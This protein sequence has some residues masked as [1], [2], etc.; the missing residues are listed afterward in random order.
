MTFRFQ[1]ILA[2]VHCG[3]FERLPRQGGVG[4]GAPDIHRLVFSVGIA[5]QISIIVW[6]CMQLLFCSAM[7]MS[8]L[9]L[10]NISFDPW[11]P[12]IGAKTQIP[13]LLTLQGRNTEKSL[14]FCRRWEFYRIGF[15]GSKQLHHNVGMLM[16]KPGKPVD[17]RWRWWSFWMNY[18]VLTI[19]ATGQPNAL[20]INRMSSGSFFC[21]QRGSALNAESLT[22]IV[23]LMALKD[24]FI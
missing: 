8:H 11:W 10:D 3:K 2:W 19:P 17:I 18:H 21:G 12:K 5:D 23:A 1:F 7:A 14:K 16:E 13:Y 24:M 20:S 6:F 9:S 22:L 4:V 15:E